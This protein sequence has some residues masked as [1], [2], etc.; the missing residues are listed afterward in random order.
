MKPHHHNLTKELTLSA[1]EDLKKVAPS[2]SRFRPNFLSLGGEPVR[3]DVI[4]FSKDVLAQVV[5]SFS[6]F[7]FDKF[8]EA[9]RECMDEYDSVLGLKNNFLSFF[10]G[11]FRAEMKALL[12]SGKSVFQKPFPLLNEM[13][14]LYTLSVSFN[15]ELRHFKYNDEVYF[16]SVLFFEYDINKLSKVRS[17]QLQTMDHQQLYRYYK[18][19][20]QYVDIDDSSA[21]IVVLD[22][23]GS[24][25]ISSTLGTSFRLKHF[26][27][28]FSKYDKFMLDHGFIKVKS[29]G[30]GMFYI[31]YGASEK[32]HKRVYAA[33]EKL[34][35]MSYVDQKV[36]SRG[37]SKFGDSVGHV[38]IIATCGQVTITHR[39][40]DDFFDL[41][42]HAVEKAFLLE[43]LTDHQSFLIDSIIKDNIASELDKDMAVLKVTT[44]KNKYGVSYS[45][46]KIKVKYHELMAKVDELRSSEPI[47]LGIGS[48]LESKIS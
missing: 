23:I 1:V 28:R 38:R 48:C 19:P 5:S 35:L 40:G 10:K 37:H 2:L 44:E 11:K 39:L 4:D 42:G 18:Y 32:I 6:K 3:S 16:Y 47:K 9:H 20:D 21:T 12:R 33:L 14:E 24:R 41:D 22:V 27:D 17:A 26:H 46:Y 36:M 25:V 8:N 7:T 29:T 34:A 31:V 30:D 15:H 13:G 43:K 45:G